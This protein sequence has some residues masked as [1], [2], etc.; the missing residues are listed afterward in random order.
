MVILRSLGGNLHTVK[1][2]LKFHKFNYVKLGAR[3]HTIALFFILQ[4]AIIG[5]DSIVL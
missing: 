4:T 2:L 1:T 5:H 3:Y